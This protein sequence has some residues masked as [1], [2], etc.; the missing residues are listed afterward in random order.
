VTQNLVRRLWWPY[1]GG[2]FPVNLGALVQRTILDG[3]EPVRVV[4]HDRVRDWGVG[5]GIDDPDQPGAS[6]VSSMWRLADADPTLQELATMAPGT[7]AYRE[8][9]GDPW[10]FD[11]YEYTVE[12][13]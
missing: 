4:V 2:R 11:D 7:L 12:E 10:Q 13:V 3:Q 5:D 1:P 6:V 8:S 9:P